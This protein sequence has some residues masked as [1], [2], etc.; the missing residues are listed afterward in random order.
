MWTYFY[1]FITFIF[2]FFG[3]DFC[4]FFYSENIFLPLSSLVVGKYIFYLWLSQWLDLCIQKHCSL[5]IEFNHW[6][7]KSSRLG[8]TVLMKQEVRTLRTCALLPRAPHISGSSSLS[9]F[10]HP[11]HKLSS[12][13]A[14]NV[15]KDG[16]I[17]DLPTTFQME[18]KTGEGPRKG[19]GGRENREGAHTKEEALSISV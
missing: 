15:P 1:H 10:R 16:Y 14:I 17:F 6:N 9:L 5:G 4:F 13:K 18:R 3:D 7:R 19:G 8:L 2:K 12:H 11:K